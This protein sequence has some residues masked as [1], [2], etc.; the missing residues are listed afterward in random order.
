MCGISAKKLRPRF[1]LPAVPG[2]HA[3]RRQFG[4][5]GRLGCSYIGGGTNNVEWASPILEN[6][7]WEARK[8][9][10]LSRWPA[11]GPTG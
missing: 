8:S 2:T 9:S 10:L 1:L 7:G 11:P 5:Q 3:V 6:W 4:K